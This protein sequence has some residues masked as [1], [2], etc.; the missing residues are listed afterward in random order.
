MSLVDLGKRLL[1]AAR[2]GQDDEVRSLMAN[3]A[4]FTTDWL[5]TSP[6]HLAAQYGHYSTAEVL[7]R[8]GVSRDARTKVDRTPLHMA[9]AEGHSSIVELLV[10]SGADINAK[11]MLKMTAL[12]WAAEHGHRGVVELLIK[13]GADTHALSKFDKTPFNIAVDR[14]NTELMLLLQEG[15]QNQVNMNPERT[16]LSSTSPATASPQFIIS[17]S[18]VVNLSDIVLT[19]A[20]ANTGAA[21]SVIAADSVDSAIQH[22]V[23]EDGQRVIT[24]V[25]DQQGN[26]GQKFFVTMQGQQMVA[27]PAGQIAEE[28]ITEDTKPVPTRK[29]K[30]ELTVNHADVKHKEPT[31]KDSREL[32]EQQ[33]KEANRKAQEY[34]QQLLRKEQEA[35]QYRLKLEAIA[36]GQ[37]NGSSTEPQE[38]VVLQEEEEEEEEVVGEEEVVMLPEGAIIIKEEPLDSTTGET[39]TLVEAADITATSE[40]TP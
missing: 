31:E 38:E 32:L 22:L 25:T 19:N 9:A 13:N 6:L 27:V 30:F 1:E 16:I 39:V 11:D 37:T 17:S 40:G 10:K 23:A 29:R 3:G 15:M 12:H 5:G 20:K 35:E 26:L 24:I 28:I 33:L 18:G 4:P 34:R 8:A 14:G 7:L 2:K 36:N 21:E